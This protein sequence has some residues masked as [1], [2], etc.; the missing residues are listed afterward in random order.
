MND[1]IQ[2]QITDLNQRLDKVDRV[3]FDPNRTI[4]ISGFK[5]QPGVSD[6]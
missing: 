2:S 5:P 3:P 1:S 4:C 6:E